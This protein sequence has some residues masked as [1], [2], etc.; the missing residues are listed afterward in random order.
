VYFSHNMRAKAGITKCKEESL[1]RNL[2][3]A[4]IVKKF[5]DPFTNPLTPVYF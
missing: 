1:S 3:V 5:T 4:E 2:T